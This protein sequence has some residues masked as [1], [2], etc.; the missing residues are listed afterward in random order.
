MQSGDFKKTGGL[1]PF[2]FFARGYIGRIVL[3]CSVNT[4]NGEKVR[5]IPNGNNGLRNRGKKKRH[6]DSPKSAAR[7]DKRLDLVIHTN[8]ENT[9]EKEPGTT[10]WDG[11]KESVPFDNRK[12]DGQ[13]ARRVRF[14]R[15]LPLKKENI[16]KSY[17]F[18]NPFFRLFNHFSTCVK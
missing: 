11:K 14:R 5:G 8:R 13:S 12:L 16:T 1:N 3:S 4:T 2:F 7:T 10:P 18:A 6:L 17:A 15:F 9:P